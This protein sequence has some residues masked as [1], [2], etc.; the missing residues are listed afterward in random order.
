M[1]KKIGIPIIIAAVVALIVF[2]AVM[3]KTFVSGPESV[4][5]APPPWIDPVTGKP[6]VQGSGSGKENPTGDIPAGA[7]PGAFGTPPGR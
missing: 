6:K 5:T 3:G 2:L 1:N 4:K 7:P